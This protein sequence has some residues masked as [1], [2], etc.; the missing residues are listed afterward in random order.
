MILRSKQIWF[1]LPAQK[2]NAFILFISYVIHF[3]LFLIIE[4]RNKEN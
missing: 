4:V 2:I 1:I 3:L